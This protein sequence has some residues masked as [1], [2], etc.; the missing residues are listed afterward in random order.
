MTNKLK[1]NNKILYTIQNNKY[2]ANIMQDV[3]WIRTLYDNYNY[4]C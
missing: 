2:I 1:Y 4:Y 3:L